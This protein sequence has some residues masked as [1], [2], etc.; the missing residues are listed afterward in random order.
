LILL[1]DTEGA[2]GITIE[3][4]NGNTFV[5]ETQS[6][7]LSIKVQGDIE[8]KCTGNYKIEAQGQVSIS[9]NAGISVESP[10]N[11]DIKGIMINLN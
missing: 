2:G 4:R 8:L 1:D 5:I 7:K 3:D 11:V 10:S 6:N 9:G